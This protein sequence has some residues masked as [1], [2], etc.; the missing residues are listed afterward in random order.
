MK[1]KKGESVY[2]A[3]EKLSLKQIGVYCENVLKIYPG[4]FLK[5]GL[6][7]RKTEEV[8]RNQIYPLSL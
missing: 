7:V 6:N 3:L 4:D 1:D 5:Y 2:E 8:E